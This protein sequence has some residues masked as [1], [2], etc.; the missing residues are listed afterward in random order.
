MNQLEPNVVQ[1]V[2]FT[3]LWSVCC[4]GF[5][6][7]A[8]MYPLE[9]RDAKIPAPLVIVSTVLWVILLIGA[10]AYAIAE[11]RWSSI[12]VVAGLLFLFIP[13]PFQAIPERWRNSSAGLAVTGIVLAA[14]LITLG[15]FTS[16]PVTSFLKSIT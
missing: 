3:V 5:L 9:S 2:W 11:L 14:A 4:L 15:V 1:L 10:F 16:N 13:E 6:Q 8:G 7:L 12:V